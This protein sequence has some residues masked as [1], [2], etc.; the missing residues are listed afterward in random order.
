MSELSLSKVIEIAEEAGREIMKI[1]ASDQFD[2]E[3]KDDDSPITRA[4]RK[5]NELIEGRLN[6]L[7]PNYPII[8][9]EGEKLDWEKRKDWKEF[10]LVDPLDGTK[11]FIKKNGEF[12]VNIALILDQIPVMGVIHAPARGVSYFAEA[13][14]G[15][16]KRE[17]A[18]E[19]RIF[20]TEKKL[21]EPLRV[22]GSRSH[23]SEIPSDFKDKIQIAERVSVGSALKFGLLAEGK[24]DLYARFSPCME[25]DV[26]AGDC[27][28]RAS[29][30]N[31]QSRRSAFRYN[32]QHLKV[33]SFTLGIDEITSCT[34]D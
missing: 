19:T 29:S 9:E 6:S 26:A 34:Q 32:N 23:K 15:A 33:H 8:S 12:T 18:N 24:A 20:S 2:I 1:Y 14:R 5:S 22:I 13:G 7:R 28:F 21:S 31:G 4:D 27:I 16:F 3:A 30:Q 10:W 25:W 11:E 17:G